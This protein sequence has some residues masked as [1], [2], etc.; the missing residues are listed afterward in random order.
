VLVA[1]ALDKCL[2]V[3]CNLLTAPA[4]EDVGAMVLSCVNGAR[5][6]RG[7][8]CVRAGM[9]LDRERRAAMMAGKVS[10]VRIV[11]IESSR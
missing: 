10:R 2:V 3:A 1:R 5:D 6:G 8:R 11:A 9:L 7:K 4:L